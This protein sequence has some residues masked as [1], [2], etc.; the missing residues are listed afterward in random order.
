MICPEC[1]AEYREGFTQCADCGVALVAAEKC[2]SEEQPCGVPEPGDPHHDP[3]CAFWK[4]DDPRVHVELCSILDDVGIPHR[5]VHRRDHVFNLANYPQ[6]EIGV[7]FSL[8]EAAETAVRQAFAL[9]PAEPQAMALLSAP[10][11][12]VTGGQYA[13]QLPSPLSPS[14]SAAIP[15]PPNAGEGSRPDRDTSHE[16]WSGPDRDLRD[17]LVAALSENG[18][19]SRILERHGFALFVAPGARERARKIV[20]DILEA[21]APE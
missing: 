5:T 9:D 8:F 2:E 10:R 21:A 16:I 6:F 12:P 7:P 4:G 19:P 1:Q 17:A 14:G 15:G 20:S 18:I 11:S 13:R 3:F